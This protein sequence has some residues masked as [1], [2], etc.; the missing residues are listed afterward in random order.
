[1][2]GLEP[3]E[4]D[5]ILAVGGSGD[6]AFAMLETGAR[7]VVADVE[8]GQIAF[9][10]HR[11]EALA[12]GDYAIFVHRQ[13]HIF[14]DCMPAISVYSERD[15]YVA[16]G[17][18]LERIRSHLGNLLVLPPADIFE[19]MRSGAVDLT[20]MY[21]CNAVSYTGWPFFSSQRFAAN[22]RLALVALRLPVG[23]LVYLS[24]GN[25][26]EDVVPPQLQLMQERTDRA[27]Q[28]EK[29]TKAQRW[30][31]TVYEKVA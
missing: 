15:A 20:K 31:P 25:L 22:E 5:V 18:R 29:S 1:M 21:A 13:K 14:T 23:G 3:K 7:V 19:V 6:Q 27:R 11:R 9:I 10:K 2:A 4:G 30:F 26:V 12:R 17:A 16:D 8:Q 28:L 24:D